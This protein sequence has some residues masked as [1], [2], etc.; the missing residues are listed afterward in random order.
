M[1][2]SQESGDCGEKSIQCRNDCADSLLAAQHDVYNV[3]CGRSGKGEL[4]S[5]WSLYE[6][7]GQYR[8]VQVPVPQEIPT[9]R[10]C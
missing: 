4:E 7:S 9:W 8:M 6:Y 5:E 10:F 1:E 3:V 2:G